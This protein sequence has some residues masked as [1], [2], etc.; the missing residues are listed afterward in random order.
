MV[1]DVKRAEPFQITIPALR[2]G[3][4]IGV[5][6]LIIVVSLVFRASMLSRAYFVEDDL[7][8]VAG[9][10]DSGFTWDYL[11]RVHK[12]HLMPGAFALVWLLTAVAPYDWALV[13]FVTIAVQRV[14]PAR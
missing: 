10:S 11:T 2:T 4:I 3:P 14:R 9:A 13:S 8:F 7:L 1:E 6:L 12:G 5:G